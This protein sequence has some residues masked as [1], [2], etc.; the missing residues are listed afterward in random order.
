MAD[1]PFKLADNNVAPSSNGSSPVT[2]GSGIGDLRRRYDF[3]GRVSEL[4]IDQTPFFRF[5]S[6]AGKKPTSDPEF[7]SLEMRQSFHKRYAYVVAHD[8]DATASTNLATDNNYIAT[9]IPTDAKLAADQIFAIKLEGDFKKPIERVVGLFVKNPKTKTLVTDSLF[10]LLL[11]GLG[12]RA[13]TEAFNSLR[14]SN[15]VAGGLSSLK[16]ALKG[17]DIVGLIKNIAA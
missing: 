7:K 12:A 9:T 13:G 14:K 1:N 10:I 4:A 3:S 5:L 6:M 8:M 17:K 16:A 15:V 2:G 11:L